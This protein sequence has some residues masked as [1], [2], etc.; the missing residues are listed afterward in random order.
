[1]GIRGRARYACPMAAPITINPDDFLET[2]EGRVW[3]PERNAEAWRRSYAALERA[4]KVSPA[5]KR[6][7]VVCGLQGAGKST[8]IAAQPASPSM[9]YF[10][11]ALPCARHRAKIIGIAR[12]LGATVEGVWIDTPL[13]V[14]IERNA[15]RSPDKM[16]PT[17]AI[18][19]VAHQFE[20]PM[21]EEGFDRVSVYHGG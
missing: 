11:A 19:A 20:N 10:D 15:V 9:I 5:P 6:V 16:V 21:V 14:A 18:V 7:V 13:D 8:W 17:P 3:T 4:I 1:M 2:P 12:R